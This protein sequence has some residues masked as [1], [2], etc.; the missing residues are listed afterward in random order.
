[1]KCVAYLLFA[2]AVGCLDAGPALAQSALGGA[3]KPQNYVGG[4]SSQKNLVVPAPRS[5]PAGAATV[6][7]RKPGK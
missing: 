6:T 4:A 2:I 5:E 3:K 7:A 1:M